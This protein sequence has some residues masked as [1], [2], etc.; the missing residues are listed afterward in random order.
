MIQQLLGI[1]HYVDKLELQERKIPHWHNISWLLESF[2][3]EKL[4]K[5]D[6]NNVDELIVD[7]IADIYHML[8]LR[9][10]C[11]LNSH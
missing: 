10:M 3:I 8:I 9:K 6:S 1:D 11:N 4:Q 5:C 2:N 7:D